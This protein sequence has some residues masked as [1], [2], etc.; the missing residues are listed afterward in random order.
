MLFLIQMMD[1]PKKLRICLTASAGGHMSQLLRIAD[2][3]DGLDTF[4]ITTTDVVCEKLSEYGDVYVVGYCNR[5]QPLRVITIFIRCLKILLRI[6]P[7][8]VISTG[9]AVGCIT[10]FISKALGAKVVWIDSITNIKKL[11]LS[12]RMVRHI[13][14]VFLVQW[15]ELIRCGRNIEYAGAVI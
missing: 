7:D 10:C 4:T 14:D 3:W 2:C 11:S 6:R 5:Q 8:V 9:A 12:G 15:P 13:A 1:R